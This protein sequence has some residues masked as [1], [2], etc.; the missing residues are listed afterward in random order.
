MAVPALLLQ[1]LL[2]LD[3]RERIELA[4]A[5]LDSVN[6]SDEMSDGERARL[7]AAIEQS[8]NESEAG[9]MIPLNE[10][11]AHLKRAARARR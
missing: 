4:H 11:L 3:E 2:A 5:L 8:V 7:H 9:R 6:D 1:Q 10:A